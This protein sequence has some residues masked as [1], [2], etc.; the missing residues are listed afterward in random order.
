[1]NGSPHPRQVDEI[2]KAA[3]ELAG[4]ARKRY[5]DEHCLDAAFRQEVEAALACFEEAIRCKADYV[6]AHFNRSLI[7]LLRGRLAGY[8]TGEFGAAPDDSASSS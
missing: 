1:M 2:S 4:E 3:S 8:M 5:L 7:L 6:Q